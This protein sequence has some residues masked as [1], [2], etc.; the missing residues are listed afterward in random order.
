MPS[1]T[2]ARGTTEVT[3]Y[4]SETYDGPTK[5]GPKLNEVELV[6]TFRGDIEGQ[7]KARVLQA[8]WPDGTI[9]YATLE[10]VVGTLA[11]REGSFLLRVDGTVRNKQNDGAWFVI[12]GSGT[13]DLQRLRGDGGFQALH[14]KQGAWS[15]NYWFE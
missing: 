12:A 8:Q 2:A 6:E 10:R 3:V 4:R 7:G 15:L 13:G 9:R 14:G 5:E 1:T 11:G